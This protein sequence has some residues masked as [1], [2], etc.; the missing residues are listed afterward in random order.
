MR[1]VVVAA[2]LVLGCSGGSARKPPPGEVQP[3][4]PDGSIALRWDASGALTG[5]EGC[6]AHGAFHTY[7]DC[8]DAELAGLPCTEW[9][10]ALTG[11]DGQP[12][13]SVSEGRVCARGVVQQVIGEAYS[14]MWGAQVTLDFAE[15]NGAN[16]FDATA[17][18]ALGFA[19]D[20]TVTGGPP[21]L[22]VR[23]RSE[24][25]PG[26]SGLFTL[27][28]PA[29]NARFLFDRPRGQDDLSP[30]AS[31]E[32][33]RSLIFRVFTNTSAPKPFD[34]CITGLRLVMPSLE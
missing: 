31:P 23:L 17:C 14:E 24:N 16:P 3:P 34:F 10:P 21:D 2:A 26:G 4:P 25:D 15:P 22:M 30:P 5:E 32:S 27:P 11:P 12:G 28:L 20:A 33:L 6:G 7:D 29:R 8:A 19:I 13:F 9:D 18:G 1:T